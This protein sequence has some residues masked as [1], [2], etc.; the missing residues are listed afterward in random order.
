MPASMALRT[1]NSTR[2]RQIA[3]ISHLAQIGLIEAGEHRDREQ[4]E[5]RFAAA[6]HRGSHDRAASVHGQ[7]VGADFG[8]L[9]HRPLHGFADIVQLQIDEHAMALGLQLADEVHPRGGVHLQADF[10]ETCG[11]AERSDEH[12]GFDR[13][14]DVERDD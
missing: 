7:K 6:R 12:S 1:R 10:V 8:H 3:G 4:F 5:R 2:R 13:R 14:F 11:I 9:R